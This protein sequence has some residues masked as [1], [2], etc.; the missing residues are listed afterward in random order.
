MPRQYSPILELM[1][2]PLPSIGQQ[3]R[4]TYRTDIR[5]VT[6]LYKMLNFY[7]FNNSL[8][9]PI[10]EVVPRC[11]KYWGICYGEYESIPYRR[12][13][14]K[15]R[16]MDKWYCKQ[17][18]INMLAHEMCHQ[19]QWDI[20]GRKRIA[21]GKDPLMSHGPSFFIFRDTLKKHGINLK[22]T[23]SSRQWFKHQN[24]FKA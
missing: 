20:I 13:A 9:M 3:K 8:P 19:Y 22:T 24:I 14:C 15:I 17:W 4:L 12:S 21:K 23:H 5:E 7:V 11:R 2:S 10:I 18:M 16:L 1:N 6:R